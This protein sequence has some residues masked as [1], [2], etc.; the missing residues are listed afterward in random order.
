MTAAG[1]DRVTRIVAVRHG[2]TDWNAQMRM[3]GQLDTAL[4]ERGRWQASRV[5][6]PKPPRTV[7]LEAAAA[8]QASKEGV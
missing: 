4:S 8:A 2:E 1:A 6:A 3:Q 7:P 5:A